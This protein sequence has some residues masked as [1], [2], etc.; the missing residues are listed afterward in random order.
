MTIGDEWTERIAALQKRLVELDRERDSILADIAKLE[1]LPDATPLR[2]TETSAQSA[3]TI[4]LSSDAKVALFRAL[5]RGRD[6]VFPR[7]WENQK[8]GKSGYAPVCR[9]EW[10]RGI[11]EKPRIKCSD[12]PNQSIRTGQR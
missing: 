2:A 10:V 8:T 9:N 6:D 11:C 7:R 3:P 4:A 1:K 12:W 5:F